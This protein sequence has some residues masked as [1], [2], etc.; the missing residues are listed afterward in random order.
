MHKE[1]RPGEQDQPSCAD[2]PQAWKMTQLGYKYPDKT[3][4]T[5]SLYCH[6][7]QNNWG[8]WIKDDSSEDQ[9]TEASD[10]ELMAGDTCAKRYLTPNETAIAITLDFGNKDV[11]SD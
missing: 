4:Q 10:Q 3:D 7:D 1:E 8:W 5:L 9:R 11:L 6:T 2:T